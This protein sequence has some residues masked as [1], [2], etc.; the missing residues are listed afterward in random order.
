MLKREIGK[1]KVVIHE[2]YPPSEGY[3]KP[4]VIAKA[5]VWFKGTGVRMSIQYV[6]EPPDEFMA[7]GSR[8]S[9]RLP[10][11]VTLHNNTKTYLILCLYE[12]R[13]SLNLLPMPEPTSIEGKSYTRILEDPTNGWH[14][15]WEV[16]ENC[17]S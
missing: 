13:R 10:E 5:T 15:G 14:C 12:A 8:Y 2:W 9:I 1:P 16:H 4:Q 3:T 17:Q 11:G 7:T 6:Y